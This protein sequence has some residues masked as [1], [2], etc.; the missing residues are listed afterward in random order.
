MD[1]CN[2]VAAAVAQVLPQVGRVLWRQ[3]GMASRQRQLGVAQ[4]QPIKASSGRLNS[5]IN[6]I[7][8]QTI[9]GSHHMP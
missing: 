7:E 9:I 2:R 6:S 8:S 5:L 3:S 4:L 1:E